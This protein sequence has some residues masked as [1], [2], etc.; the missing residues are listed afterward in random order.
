MLLILK[1]LNHPEYVT[2]HDYFIPIS[3]LS[4]GY[5]PHDGFV[6]CF[7]AFI[8]KVTVPAVIIQLYEQ[9]LNF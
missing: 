6:F 2:G 8:K 5:N 4:T 9:R 7:N 3:F 1:L